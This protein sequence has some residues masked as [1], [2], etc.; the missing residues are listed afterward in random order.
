MV[1]FPKGIYFLTGSTFLHYP[2][3]KLEEQKDIVLRQIQKL[4]KDKGIQIC[5][6]SIQMN[7]Y[8]ILFYAKRETDVATVKQYMNGGTS[9]VYN[10]IYK[11]KYTN[12]WGTMKTIRVWNE[13]M[14]WKIIGYVNG[15]LLKHREVGTFE[16]L[17]ET[18]FSSYKYFVEKY[19]HDMMKEIIYKV[20]DVG[21]SAEGEVGVEGL[22]NLKVK[23][24]I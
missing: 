5:A 23:I 6:F 24:P 20:V 8:H 12:M 21:E 16:E 7:H 15:N 3:F 11:K 17:Y 19:G 14:Y 18:E 10:K 13:Q 9:F 4:K 22:K 1:N 2:Y